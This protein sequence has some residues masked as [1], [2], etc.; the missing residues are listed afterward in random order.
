MIWSWLIHGDWRNAYLALDT[1]FRIYAYD[2]GQTML[3]PFVRFRPLHESYQVFMM[4]ARAGAVIRGRDLMKLLA[5]LNSAQKAGGSLDLNLDVA[6]AMF[7][8][9]QAYLASGGKM[10]VRHLDHLMKGVLSLLDRRPTA[11]PGE[12]STIRDLECQLV[13][14]LLNQLIYFFRTADCPLVL[15]NYCTLITMS[16]RLR[17]SALLSLAMQDFV[18]ARLSAEASFWECLLAAAG[19]LQRPDLV[20]TAWTNISQH[21]VTHD[22][23]FELRTWRA[24]AQSA[25]ETGLKTYV[26]DQVD[27]FH[28]KVDEYTYREIFKALS[29]R[30]PWE[31]AYKPISSKT[32]YNVRWQ[33]MRSIQK[34]CE[35]MGVLLSNIGKRPFAKPFSFPHTSIWDWPNRPNEQW[36]RGLY[37]EISLSS[38]ANVWGVRGISKPTWSNNNRVDWKKST[39]SPTGYSLGQLRYL[40]TKS[41]NDLLIQAEIWESKKHQSQSS[42]EIRKTLIVNGRYGEFTAAPEALETDH[43]SSCR[44]GGGE[45]QTDDRRALAS[46]NFQ[47]TRLQI[48]P[49]TRLTMIIV[50]SVSIH[51]TCSGCPVHADPAIWLRFDYL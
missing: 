28:D 29:K 12:L 17:E 36:Q 2:I 11:I 42:A 16:G 22:Y 39:T 6:R 21:A 1:A 49:T 8:L 9:F 24:L 37:D 40:N 35:E 14:K 20:Y 10:D 23:A 46:E 48:P 18:K 44:Y 26:L 19:D 45:I 41:I 3:D 30:A 43:N 4:F 25:K 38:S 34:F 7:H 47:P 31:D 15:A 32:P 33:R 5:Q 13:W 51:F 27:R 50:R